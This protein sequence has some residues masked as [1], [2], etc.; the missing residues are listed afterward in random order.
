[1]GKLNKISNKLNEVEIRALSRIFRHWV[2][3][4]N[5]A[6]ISL[7]KWVSMR[8]STDQEYNVLQHELKIPI[9]PMDSSS[10]WCISKCV[11]EIDRNADKKGRVVSP[12]GLRATITGG[13]CSFL[14]L[15][16]QSCC[17]RVYA[18]QRCQLALRM[19][20]KQHN[21]HEMQHCVR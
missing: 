2:Q 7:Q 15:I 10:S 11:P 3:V 6:V 8:S 4:T 9:V 13:C 20:N 19:T 16:P 5:F 18:P 14:S 21:T 12:L 1:M 17:K